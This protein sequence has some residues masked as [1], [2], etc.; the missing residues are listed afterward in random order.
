MHARRVIRS[1][2][3]ASA[4]IAKAKLEEKKKGTQELNP[5]KRKGFQI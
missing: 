3:E 2:K 1:N 5:R 4:V